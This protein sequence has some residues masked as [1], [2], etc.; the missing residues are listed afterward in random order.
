MSLLELAKVLINSPNLAALVSLED[1][2]RFCDIVR[3]LKDEIASFQPWY[4]TG[5]P[6][7]LPIKVHNFLMAAL[8]L[9]DEATKIIW[10]TL[11][12]FAWNVPPSTSP[13]VE[14]RA[15]SLLPL[16]LE[17]GIRQGLGECFVNY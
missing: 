1:L 2:Q 16:F 10:Y 15:R 5:P 13:D 17:H 6:D 4:I 9:S 11:R 8:S 14:H 7:T 3:W 12:D